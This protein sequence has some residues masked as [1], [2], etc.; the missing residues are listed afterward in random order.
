MHDEY[1]SYDYV[2]LMINYLIDIL[3]K[4]KFIEI[5]KYKEK[6]KFYQR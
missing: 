4:D 2:Y 3:G 1:D 5:L 6:I